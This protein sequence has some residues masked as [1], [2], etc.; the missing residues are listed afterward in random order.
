MLIY[1]IEIICI[2][3]ILIFL[4]FLCLLNSQMLILIILF[5]LH[6]IVIEEIFIKVF[7][8]FFYYLNLYLFL[9]HRIINISLLS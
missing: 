7:I 9:F 5:Y 8:R 2:I 1:Y 4:Y 6:F 3:K